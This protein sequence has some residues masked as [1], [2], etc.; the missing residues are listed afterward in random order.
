M[1]EKKIISW[2]LWL[3]GEVIIISAFILFKGE[4]AGNVTVLNIVI[5]S[6]IYN[7]FFLDILIPWVD[8]SDLSHRRIGSIGLRWSVTL[9]YAFL[10]II[11]IIL[12]HKY[13]NLSFTTLLLIHAAL[14]FFMLLGMLGAFLSSG[15]TMEVHEK[16]RGNTNGIAEMKKAVY[17]LRNKMAGV[18]DL[19]ESLIDKINKL[20]EELQYLS[21]VNNEDS[22]ELEKSFIETVNDINF[23]L[24][25]HSLNKEKIERDLIKCEHIF[26]NRKQIY[27][28]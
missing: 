22:Y 19:P 23:A 12:S 18:G 11:T 25:N 3:F 21:P 6:I 13:F 8:F 7:L 10:A 16:Q 26:Q 20:N 5:S 28:N 17:N 24:V 4:T 14:L 27:S 9:I 2:V 15:K 1:S